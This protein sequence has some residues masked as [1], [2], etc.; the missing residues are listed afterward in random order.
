MK[1]LYIKI[2]NVKKDYRS[3]SGIR[4]RIEGVKSEDEEEKSERK[5]R[6]KWRCGKRFEFK[7]EE[8]VRRKKLREAAVRF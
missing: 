1:R 3:E 2:D 5:K 6:R 7:K 4:C 8:R